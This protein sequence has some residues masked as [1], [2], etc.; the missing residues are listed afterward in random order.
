MFHKTPENGHTKIFGFAA[1]KSYVRT[2]P[3]CLFERLKF[4]TN[5]LN[6]YMNH[7]IVVIWQPVCKHLNFVNFLVEIE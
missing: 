7:R 1:F 3:V 6:K 4:L 2:P 5:M